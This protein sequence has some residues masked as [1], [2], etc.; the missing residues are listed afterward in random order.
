MECHGDPLLG[1]DELTGELYD[2]LE[3]IAYTDPDKTQV[4]SKCGHAEAV[5]DAP[6]FQ[7]TTNMLVKLSSYSCTAA[8]LAVGIGFAYMYLKYQ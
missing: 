5:N 8:V 7:G 2:P 1:P 3:N 4:R 6:C